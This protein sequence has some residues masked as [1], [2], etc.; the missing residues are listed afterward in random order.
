[1]DVAER[2]HALTRFTPAVPR[3]VLVALATA[4]P[5]ITIFVW[6]CLLYG[7][8]AWGNAAPWLVTDEFERAQ[9]SRAVAMTGHEAIRTMPHPFDTLYVYLIAPAWWIHDTTRA[10]G[11][12]KAIGVATMTCAL[13]PSYALARLF[14][15]KRWAFFAATA[16]VLIPAFAYASMLLEEPLAYFW[17]ALSFYLV[18]HAMLTPRIRWIVP[19][20]AACLIAPYVRGQLGVI[21]PGAFMAGFAFWFTSESGR[22]VW[23]RWKIWHWIAFAALVVAVAAFLDIEAARH[24]D[25]W[26]MA[27]EQFR[28]RMFTYGLWAVGALTIGVGV[29]PSIASLTAIVRPKGEPPSREHRAYVCLI[30]PMIVTFTFYTA[31]K[32]AYVS[33]Q[34]LTFL[35]ERNVVYLSPLLFLGTAIVLARRRVRLAALLVATSAVLYLVLTTPYKMEYHFF[36]DAPGLSILQSLNRTYGLTPHSAGVLLVTLAI[37]S[38]V[39]LAAVGRVPRLAATVLG[40]VAVAFVLSWNAYG[41]ITAARSSHEYANSLINNMPRPLNWIDQA[42]PDNADVAYLGQSVNT[43]DPNGVLQLEFWNRTLRHVW[44]TDG[45]AP[46]PGANITTQV[47]SPDGRIDPG[48]NMKYMVSDYGISLVGRVLDQ[49]VHIGGG[50]PL[51]W[52]LYKLTPPTRLRSTVEGLYTDG[53]G[54]PETGLNQFSIPGN[55]KSW[56]VVGVSRSGGGKT[57]PASVKVEVGKLSLGYGARTGANGLQPVLRHEDV[58][59]RRRLHVRRNLNHVF[60]FLAPKPPFRVETEVTPFSPYLVDPRSSD[61]RTLGAQVDYRVVPVVPHAQPGRGA[62]VTGIDPDGWMSEDST[63][64]MWSTPFQQAGLA[65]VTV[66]R[67]LWGGPDVPGHVTMTVSSLAYDKNLNLID[68]KTSSRK[69]WTVHSKGN[70]TFLL[71]T[72]TPPFRVHVHIT[73][74]FV[75]HKL[76]PRFADIRHLGAEIQYGFRTF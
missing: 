72:P 39:L 58:I 4:L 11:A 68:T 38:A 70:R 75:P 1:M 31:V 28:N 9:L 56:L 41:E 18:A 76:D 5:L 54:Q 22:R 74:T 64:T 29:L 45:T 51:P 73:P 69:T 71:P 23:R 27:T 67:K 20:V 19:A 7:W 52:T 47:L 49:K 61:R 26:K 30:V 21:I 36:F 8:E 2:R 14:V 59:Y 50:A 13:F 66:S 53:W 10:Y 16:A 43:S 62:D 12:A 63:Y 65:E 33:R 37:V 48:Q 6:L 46:G 15:P 55:E 17:A 42:V 57:V 32:A 34:G 60:V 44:S 3:R 25:A 24:S 40:L 35:N